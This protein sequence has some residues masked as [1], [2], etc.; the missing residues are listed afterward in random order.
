[1]YKQGKRIG[2]LGGG[3][4]GRM[5]LQSAVDYDLFLK[6][7]DPDP[8]APCKLLAHQFEVGSLTDF[9]TVYTFGQNVDV[10]TIEIENVNA[11]ALAE[12]EKEGVAVYPKPATIALIQDKRLQKEFFVEKGFPTSPFVCINSRSELANHPELFPGVQK[13]AK[14]G[15][16]GKGVLVLE[17]IEQ[18]NEDGFTAPSLLEKKVKIDKEIAVMV[19]RS[20]SGE[21]AAYPPVELVYTPANLVDY[22][23]SP[24]RLTNQQS[25]EATKLATAIATAIDLVGVLAV[26]LFL[27][28]DGNWQVNELAP[29]PH[30]SGHQTI[31]AC[32]TSQYEQHLRAIL[33]LPLGS[34]E[35]LCTSAMV[36]LV[37]AEGATGP[38][39]YQGLNNILKIPGAHVH[40]Y[41]K[42]QTKPNRKMGH[43]TLLHKDATALPA[44][45][46][47]VKEQ[48]QVVSE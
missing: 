30:N 38:V 27:D 34:T 39:V 28:T 37:G 3:Q 1:M 19:A 13:T 14:A 10:L 5:L 33:N 4:L 47:Q 46:K 22:L 25:E 23:L 26:E 18:A 24:A 17:T 2:V 43:I 41:G 29:R 8:N 35:L 6:M 11:D 21:V 15:Y 7:L 44:L 36:N 12:L 48:V 20:A 45:V 31:E 9:A 40:L 42:K 16:D 32:F